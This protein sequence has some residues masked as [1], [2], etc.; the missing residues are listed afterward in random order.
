[1]PDEYDNLPPNAELDFNDPR[2]YSFH[3]DAVENDDE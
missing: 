1:M 3:S 2:G